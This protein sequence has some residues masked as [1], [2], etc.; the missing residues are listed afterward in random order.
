LLKIAA[1]VCEVFGGLGCFG[2]S[3]GTDAN[4]LGVFESRLRGAGAGG[5]G[6]PVKARDFAALSIQLQIHAQEFTARFVA[7]VRG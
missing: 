6:F 5:F 3:G 2:I 7:L 1:K 4:R